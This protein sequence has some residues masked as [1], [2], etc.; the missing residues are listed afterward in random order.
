VY[1][2]NTRILTKNKEY[3]ITKKIIKN[4]NEEFSIEAFE[5]SRII[6]FLEFPIAQPN[7]F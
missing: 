3:V 5:L 6:I 7:S 4:R 1:K 2:V